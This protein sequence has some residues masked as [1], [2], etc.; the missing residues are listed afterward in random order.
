MLFLLFMFAQA[1]ADSPREKTAF[2]QALEQNQMVQTE[3]RMVT[4]DGRRYRE[5]SYKNK[6]YYY[7]FLEKENSIEV[8]CTMDS[9]LTPSLAEAG[10]TM[11]KRTQVF[12]Q[13]L[14]ETCMNQGGG[15]SRRVIVFDPRLGISIPDD[16]KSTIKNKKI[17]IGPTGPGFSG[18]W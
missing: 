18:E 7:R 5:V 6:K 11:F 12:V 13:L 3:E 1:R 10:V 8:D 17:Y 16:P 2:E 4:H 9:K 14:S 15:H